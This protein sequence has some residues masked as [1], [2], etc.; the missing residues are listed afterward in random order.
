MVLI[1]MAMQSI[2]FTACLLIICLSVVSKGNLQPDERSSSSFESTPAKNCSSPK[3]PIADAMLKW[4]AGRDNNV[5][6]PGE[7]AE[8]VCNE[9]F[10]QI[11]WLETLTCQNNGNWSSNSYVEDDFKSSESASGEL[12]LS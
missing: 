8:F 10:R 1:S 11:G 3:P 2:L 6:Q 9:G 5:F 12:I 7:K 4:R